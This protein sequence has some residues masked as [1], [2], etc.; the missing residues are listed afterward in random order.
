MNA[1]SLAAQRHPV[2]ALPVIARRRLLWIALGWVVVAVLEATA[3][4]VLARAFVHHDG[5]IWVLACAATAIATTVLVQRAGFFSGARLAGDLYAALGAALARAKLSWFTDA[6]RTRITL[7]AGQGIPGFM[8]VPAHQLQAFLHTPLLPLL[9][10]PG[11][12]LLAGTSMAVL[13]IALLALSLG[14][15]FLAQHA[16][17]R[18]DARRH[19]TAQA[20]AQATLELVNHLELL[21]TA[22]GPQRATGRIEQRW[23]EQ[24]H[25]LAAT[26]RA[27][28]LATLISSLASV[29][30]LAGMAAGATLLG[31]DSPSHLLALL[32]LTARAAAPLDE[33][34]QAGLRVNDVLASLRNYRQTISAPA[35]LEPAPHTAEQ[36]ANHHITVQQLSHAPVLHNVNADISPGSRVLISGPSGSGKSTLLELMMRFDDPQQGRIT[37]GGVA[38]HQMRYSD[39]IEH[40]AYVPQQPVVFTGTLLDNIRLGCP[41]ATKVEAEVAARHAALGQVIDRSPQGL[42]QSVGHQGAALSGGERQRVA[43]ARALLKTAPILLL[44]EATCALDET[45]ER[46]VAGYIRTLSATVIVVTHRDAAIWQPTHHINLRGAC[47]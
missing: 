18:A 22:A 38:L 41:Q 21:R 34:A 36:P 43:L 7:L 42:H 5:P 17:S 13:A 14:I 45:T 16:L 9:L 15:Q 32:L 26:N 25:T 12:A 47:P 23:Y 27:A 4:T 8:S 11:V 2:C 3:Y 37:L 20:S 31:V 24:E 39:L 46:E 40:L 30:P 10:L 28:A 29:L 44:D 6:Q 35:L 1:P 33:L 19:A